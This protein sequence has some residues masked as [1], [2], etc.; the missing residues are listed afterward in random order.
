MSGKRIIISRTDGIGDVILAL[1]MAGVL[2]KIYPDC[3]VIFLG[4][5]Y[6]KP[7]IETCANIDEF[8]AW[9][10]IEKLDER[11]S[12][13]NLANLN[14]DIILHVFPRRAVA[15]L[16]KKAGIPFR[17]GTS[18][19]A[20]HW[21]T[22]NRLIRLSRRKSTHH[23]AQLNLKIL[24]SLGGKKKYTLNEIPEYFGFTKVKPLADPIRNLLDEKRF[25]LLVHPLSKGSAREWGIENFQELL[26][27]LPKDKFKIFIS[28]TE[29]EG[30]MVRP[31]LVDKYPE[32]IDM[33]GKL[34]LDELIS[35]ISHM[36]GVLAASTGPLHIAAALGRYA[37]GLYAPMRPIHP[38]RWAPIGKKAEYLVKDKYCSKC[39]KKNR[40]ECI[41]SITPAEVKGQI[42]K[43]LP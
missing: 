29:E 35:F 10:E 7:I 37:L 22:C 18:S 15:E 21:S 6:T 39:K 1:P 34:S 26:K 36:D 17:V 30:I 28:G 3:K 9:D 31:L 33:S 11:E 14:A 20:F 4:R 27:I 32:V 42:L 19:R 25:N 2:K 41:E 5:N 43:M 40:C 8:F 16:A 24:V 38:G 12:I 23:E 13:K